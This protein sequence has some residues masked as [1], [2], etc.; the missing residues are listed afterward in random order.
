MSIPIFFDHGFPGHNRVILHFPA[1]D[2]AVPSG[3]GTA[4]QT[5]IPGNDGEVGCRSPIMEFRVLFY[6]GIVIADRIVIDP[7]RPFL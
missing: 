4:I 7:A 1:F 5:G 2:P 3:P 6:H